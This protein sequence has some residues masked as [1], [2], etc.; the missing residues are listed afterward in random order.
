[1]RDVAVAGHALG[2][3]RNVLFLWE[4]LR[5][6]G[7]CSYSRTNAHS[8]VTAKRS[9]MV[10]ITERTARCAMGLK[11]IVSAAQKE[12]PRRGATLAGLK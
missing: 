12:M 10:R 4:R 11:G 2:L 8:K 9:N 5:A 7:R 6:V 3:M 1:M